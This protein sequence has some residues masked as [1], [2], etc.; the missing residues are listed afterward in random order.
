M[1]AVSKVELNNARRGIVAG[2]SSDLFSYFAESF[3]IMG[4]GLS[5]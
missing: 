5:F 1:L 2:G 3:E 4:S